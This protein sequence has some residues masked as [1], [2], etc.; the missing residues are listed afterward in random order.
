MELFL[1][2]LLVAVIAAISIA[3]QAR[4]RADKALER[5]DELE[6]RDHGIR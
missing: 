6:G 2:G 1:V 5:L 3:Q 4:S